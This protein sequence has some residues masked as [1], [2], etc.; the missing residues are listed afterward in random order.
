MQRIEAGLRRVAATGALV[1]TTIMLLAAVLAPSVSTGT[2]AAFLARGSAEQV[3][4]T[5]AR[6]GALLTLLDR[7]GHKVQA[8]RVDS[9][10]ALLLRNVAPG[11]SPGAAVAR[12]LAD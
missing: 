7:R 2:T 12:D 11:E 4:I 6:P 9:L 10:G 5:G 1:I 8:K 3:D